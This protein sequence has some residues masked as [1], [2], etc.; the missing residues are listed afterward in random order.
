MNACANDN[1]LLQFLDGELNAA[2]N[3]H[4]VTHLEGCLACQARLERLTRGSPLL[5]EGQPIETVGN[6]SEAITHLASTE[7]IAREGGDAQAR[8]ESD[9]SQAS[10]FEPQISG[11]DNGDS[12]LGSAW[13]IHLAPAQGKP[14]AGE[15]AGADLESQE[16]D[17]YRTILPASTGLQP[18]PAGQ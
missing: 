5:A 11:I 4:L 6:G 13:H 2:A 14:G 7:V 16:S 17:P 12:S 15:K 3:A 18:P 1:D 9:G 10:D 8:V